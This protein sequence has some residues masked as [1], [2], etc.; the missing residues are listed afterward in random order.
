MVRVSLELGSE[1]AFCYLLCYF[2]SALKVTILH[3][4]AYFFFTCAPNGMIELTHA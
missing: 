1:A 2:Q 3:Q 4:Y